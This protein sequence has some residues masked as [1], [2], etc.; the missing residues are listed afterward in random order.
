MMTILCTRE[1]AHQVRPSFDPRLI[2]TSVSRGD[3]GIT[4]C[5]VYACRRQF[6][7]LYYRD[8][9]SDRVQAVAI[10]TAQYHEYAVPIVQINIYG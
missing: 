4:D 6:A 10:A 9:Q 3:G 1:R 5:K 2:R 8:R 7:T